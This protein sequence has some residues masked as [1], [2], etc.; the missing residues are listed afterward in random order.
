MFLNKPVVTDQC[1]LD[2]DHVSTISVPSPTAVNTRA[3]STDYTEITWTSTGSNIQRFRIFVSEKDT[4]GSTLNFE[5][6]SSNTTYKL[7][8]PKTMWGKDYLVTVQ[9]INKNRK[10]SPVSEPAVFRVANSTSATAPAPSLL[11]SPIT[12]IQ[13]VQATYD[14]ITLSWPE[15]SDAQDY[16]VKWD[17]G[18]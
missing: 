12:R 14:K 2:S 16:K 11:P 7:R 3:L 9:A 5:T 18:D 13:V 15:V 1:I 17:K 10:L 4:S 8:T 6:P